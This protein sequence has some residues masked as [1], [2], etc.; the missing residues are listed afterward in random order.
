MGGVTGARS[1]QTYAATTTTTFNP[2]TRYIYVFTGTD[3]L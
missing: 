2:E 1:G 3:Y